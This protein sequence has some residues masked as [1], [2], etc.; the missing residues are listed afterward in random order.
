MG[1]LNYAGWLEDHATDAARSGEFEET[2]EE[3]GEQCL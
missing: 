2:E 1:E 3:E